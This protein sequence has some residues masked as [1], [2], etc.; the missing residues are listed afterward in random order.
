[1]SYETFLTISSA[2]DRE[3]DDLINEC[4]DII[5]GIDKILGDF[6]PSTILDE[7][8]LNE[9]GEACKARKD[10][11]SNQKD[12]IKDVKKDIQRAKR[13]LSICNERAKN[14]ANSKSVG[15]KKKK[16]KA[17]SAVKID[18]ASTQITKLKIAIKKNK[19]SLK[20]VCLGKKILN[21]VFGKK[22]K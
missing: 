15:L 12:Q 2:Q 10:I 19:A 22:K 16:C 5:T 3:M 9:F 20:D 17:S 11:I 18:K 14:S 7:D 21:K 1:M 4:D 13:Q 6:D 8:T